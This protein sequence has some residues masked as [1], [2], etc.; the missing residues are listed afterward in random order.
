MPRA[1]ESM[2]FDAEAAAPSIDRSFAATAEKVDP[3]RSSAV[4]FCARFNCFDGHWL[5]LLRSKELIVG[6]LDNRAS[7]REQKDCGSFGRSLFLQHS[8]SSL[9]RADAVCQDDF[10]VFFSDSKSREAE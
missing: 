4:I 3:V 7:H 2:R 8:D 6:V 1:K 9:D 10:C 5:A